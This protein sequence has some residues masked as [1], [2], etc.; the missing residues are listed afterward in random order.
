MSQSDEYVAILRCR[1]WNVWPEKNGTE[2][3]PFSIDFGASAALPARLIVL[4][5]AQRSA[6]ERYLK[7]ETNLG[8][9]LWDGETRGLHRVRDTVLKAPEDEVELTLQYR[10]VQRGEVDICINFRFDGELPPPLI[11]ALRA[12]AYALMSL[13]NLQLG[14]YMVPAAPFQVRKVLP[15]GGG[16][17]ESA[18][19]LAVHTRQT[20]EKETLGQTISSIANVLLD[21]AY[22]EKLR[23]ALELYAA[24]FTEQQ[25][26]VR[27]LLLVIAI[28]SLAK[29]TAKHQVAIDLLGRW[30]QELETEVSR[31]DPSSEEFHSLEALSRELVF[32]SEDSVR[33][34][35]RKLFASLPGVGAAESAELQHRALRVYDK[36]STLVHDGYLPAEEL[37]PLE[38]EARALLE[39][40]F[41]I[42]IEQ[43][44]NASPGTSPLSGPARPPPNNHPRP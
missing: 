33:S 30:R 23:V 10:N 16:Q 4:S 34:Q 22:G 1:T 29:P 38:D 25:V 17:L 43:G 35:I 28:E 39:K 11:E 7:E 26:R 8:P 5:Y 44:K 32:R 37:P 3:R 15:S 36:R 24:H 41:A 42:T 6:P 40:V 2:H 9:L 18:I 19:L 13:L 27:F 12:T 14:D 20:L 21:S 31:F